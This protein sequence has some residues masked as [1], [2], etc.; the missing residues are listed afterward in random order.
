MEMN[1]IIAGKICTL[2]VEVGK[3][4]LLNFWKAVYDREDDSYTV[5][6]YVF[7]QAYPDSRTLYYEV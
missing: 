3:R 7:F 2:E 6:N 4:H 1:D 5:G